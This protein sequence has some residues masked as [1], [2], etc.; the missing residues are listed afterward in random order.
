VTA[1]G[2]WAF[3]YTNHWR[4]EN[5]AFSN[6]W[7]HLAD[8]IAIVNPAASC[9]NGNGYFQTYLNAVHEEDTL[10]SLSCSASNH[11]LFVDGALGGGVGGVTFFV[12]SNGW[13]SICFTNLTPLIYTSTQTYSNTKEIQ[14]YGQ[15][16]L[17]ASNDLELAC[18]S[19]PNPSNDSSA[20]A[21]IWVY[22]ET[23]FYS[24]GHKIIRNGG[25]YMILGWIEQSG[26]WM[27]PRIAGDPGSEFIVN[28][29]E[30][31]VMQNAQVEIPTIV[32]SINNL[33]NETDR[34]TYQQ[35]SKDS[36]VD[37]TLDNAY[38][39]GPWTGANGESWMVR[40]NDGDLTIKDF[41]LIYPT[42]YYDSNDLWTVSQIIFNGDLNGDGLIYKGYDNIASGTISFRGSIS[43]GN[44][45][46]G[47][48]IFRSL[49][50]A[51]IQLGIVPDKVDLNIDVDGL[52]D[53]IGIDHDSISLIDNNQLWLSL[54]DLKIN[55]SG[56]S[57]PYR[58]N[59]IIYCDA[60]FN[61]SK[62]NFNSIAWSD[63]TRAG[64]VVVEG[65]NVYITGIPASTNTFFDA[66]PEKLIF[67][68]GETQK[69]ILVQSPFSVN[70][71]CSSSQNWIQI[72]NS[73][74]LD[75][76]SETFNVNIPETL[77]VNPDTGRT[78]TVVHLVSENDSSIFYD[79]DV[80][81][82]EQGYFEL[83]ESTLYFIEERDD[84]E[85]V[86]AYSPFTVDLSVEPAAGDS[87]ISINST[88]IPV[89][90][91]LTDD[92][93]YVE[94]NVATNQ[95]AGTEGKICFSNLT[96]GVSH[97]VDIK[98]VENGYFEVTPAVLEIAPGETKYFNVISPLRADV[99][100][101]A[102]TNNAEFAIT[103]FVSLDGNG[104]A[105]PVIVPINEIEGAT[106]TVTFVNTYFTNIIHTAEVVIVPEPMGI[107]WI[108]GLL[109][110]WIIGR[111]F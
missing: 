41:G 85:Y 104:F 79:V 66:Q 62:S 61:P 13:S 50:N 92:Y 45:D 67:L 103:D 19:A 101:T 18:Y 90:F 43:P 83:D 27:T 24:H 111:K 97:S 84:S 22:D 14:F 82:L 72:P 75:N 105:V 34:A 38:Y 106:G 37:V 3:D 76:S 54:I 28:G 44:N 33:Q 20:Y 36:D 42:A 25:G 74:S 58:S 77:P 68:H 7:P 80:F 64:Q 60:G 86:G 93:E 31:Y 100:I 52:G 98:I 9:T 95:P 87:W 16:I 51:S 73:V 69:N 78:N 29:S 59:M 110:L 26:S 48:L 6:S 40:E 94:I 89:T 35:G 99:N 81:V 1:P 30:L 4:S 12:S 8:D 108:I 11:V 63:P 109:E 91:S 56:I 47:Q 53:K 15:C 10:G 71:N 2:S 39:H 21:A 17:A 57:N 32:R 23:V 49:T 70:V 65:S 55:N 5:P 88:N 46:N 102:D 96:D 107:L